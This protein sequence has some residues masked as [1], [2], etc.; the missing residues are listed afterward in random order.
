MDIAVL[1]A[2]RD[3]PAE[4]AGLLTPE[5]IG[6]LIRLLDEKDD[7]IRYPAFLVLC[8]RSKTHPDVYPFWDELAA[9]LDD[10]NSY[11]RSIGAKLTALNVRWDREKKFGGVFRRYVRLFTD[12]KPITARLALQSVPDWTEYEPEL[13]EETVSILTAV[14]LM[15]FRESM[16]K[17][18]LID[19]MNA[20]VAIRRVRPS[21]AVADYLMNAMTG[22]V[23]D[24]KT[25]KAIE[26]II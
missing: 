10:E 9:K 11:R 1:A 6:W 24:K 2:H 4:L 14:D 13:L 19:I 17:L 12:E 22:G 26:E 7:K 23:L 8:E 18:I 20:L 21:D 15:S 3:D 16:R 25:K 5:D